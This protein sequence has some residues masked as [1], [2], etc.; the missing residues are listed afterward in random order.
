MNTRWKP[1]KMVTLSSC[2]VA[3]LPISANAVES[4]EGV[5]K[6]I[7]CVTDNICPNDKRDP[8]LRA[9][10]DFVIE[11]PDGDFF[12]VFNIDRDTK[13]RFALDTVK[14]TGDVNERYSSIKADQ[15]EI[16]RGDSYQTIWKPGRP[17][18]PL[19]QPGATRP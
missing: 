3:F 7:R 16:K 2:I 5:I 13:L 14:I 10:S 1:L 15:M 4:V 12:Y 17:Y 19:R 9:E 6:G 18:N 11:Q 8:R